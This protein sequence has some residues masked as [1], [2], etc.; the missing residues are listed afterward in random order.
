[1]YPDT[2]LSTDRYRRIQVARPGY[3]LTVSRRRNKYSFM[4]RST[5]IPLYPA[6]DGRQTGDSFVADTRNMSTA[7]SGYNLYPATC[8]LVYPCLMLNRLVLTEQKVTVLQRLYQGHQAA[9]GLRVYIGNT[10]RLV[11]CGESTRQG[12]L[13]SPVSFNCYSERIVRESA[14]DVS[15]IGVTINGRNINN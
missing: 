13:V 8:V 1:M 3:M 2:Y 14:D 10:D 9:V 12:C 15:W 5:C 11:H 7:T 6:T 4:S